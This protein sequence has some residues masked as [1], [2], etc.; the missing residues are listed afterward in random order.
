L[1][2]HTTEGGIAITFDCPAT[3]LMICVGGPHMTARLGATGLIAT[4][5][6][7]TRDEELVYAQVQGPD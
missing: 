3:A 6:L 5:L 4:R 7:G 1:H 2:Y